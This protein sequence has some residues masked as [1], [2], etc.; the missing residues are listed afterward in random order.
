MASRIIGCGNPFRRDDGA[1]PAV[2]RALERLAPPGV[3][4]RSARGEGLDLLEALAGTAWAIVVDAMRSGR[5]P[6]SIVRLESGDGLERAGL[7]SS[8]G[9]G[10]VHAVRLSR[11]LGAAPERLEVY[12]IEG[13][14]FGAGEGL[15]PAVRRAVDRLAGR[16]C[17]L[18]TRAD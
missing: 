8:H 18:C 9:L 1:G 14:D 5:R 13:G 17:R 16:L 15:T 11:S 6:G 4:V 10:V 2:A 12:G 7:P 3:E